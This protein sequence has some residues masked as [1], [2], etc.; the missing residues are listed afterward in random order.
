LTSANE[1]CHRI[2]CT[3]LHHH[4][5]FCTLHSSLLV[6]YCPHDFFL[7]FAEAQRDFGTRVFFDVT[8]LNCDRAVLIVTATELCL[9][10]VN[11][12]VLL[13]VQLRDVVSVTASAVKCCVIECATVTH[14]VSALDAA[15]VCDALCR[16]DAPAMASTQPIPRAAAILELRFL[17][18]PLLTADW[19]ARVRVL[20]ERHPLCN[21]T[22]HFTVRFPP[23][24]PLH[25]N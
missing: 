2:V 4:N 10:R 11:A 15:A 8:Y 5:D 25:H 7:L 16:R 3:A 12:T 21:I 24:F 22:Q 1:D 23:F 13:K 19:R 20:L 17:W 9:M 14:A 6:A 18:F